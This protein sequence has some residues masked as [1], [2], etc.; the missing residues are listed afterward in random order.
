M[1]YIS[2]DSGAFFDDGQLDAGTHGADWADLHGHG[3]F[4]APGLD[5]D[6]D[7]DLRG[8]RRHDRHGRRGPGR[9]GYGDYVDHVHPDGSAA[10]HDAG[11]DGHP[12]IVAGGSAGDG[13]FATVGMSGDPLLAT[14][15][16]TPHPGEAAR[17]RGWATRRRATDTRPARR[18]IRC[19]RRS[20][21]LRPRPVMTRRR[22][23]PIRPRFA[24]TAISG[25]SAVETKTADELI[26]DSGGLGHPSVSS[27]VGG[28]DGYEPVKT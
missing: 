26:I 9:D 28:T 13:G 6:L 2:H 16:G 21:S 24:G 18:R 27:F 11:G 20:R 5:L 17:T 25:G 10:V 8:Q 12:D 19:S 3:Q 22:R 7:L 14:F 1:N 15:I 4:G 23:T